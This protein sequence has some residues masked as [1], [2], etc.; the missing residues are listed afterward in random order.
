MKN[1]VL[2]K[3]LLLIPIVFFIGC[4]GFLDVN[5]NPNS[6]E[7]VPPKLLLPSV[8]TG[9]AF[10]NGNELNRFAS[11]LM[12][13]NYGAGGSP[14]AWDVYTLDGGSFGNQ[15]RFEIYGGSLVACSKLITAADAIGAKSYT[16]I[17]KIMKAYSFCLATDVWGDVPYSQAL[18]G[19]AGT[20]QPRIDKQ[21]DIYKGNSSLGI[22]SIFDLVREGLTDLSA[23]SKV[24]PAIDDIVYGGTMA[25]WSKAGYTLM[26]KM[27]LQISDAEP[28]LAA[29]IVNEVLTAN[30]Y[31]K[32]N[33]QNLSVNFGTQTGSQSPVYTWSNI[34]TS[35]FAPDMNVSSGYLDLMSGTSVTADVAS[36]LSPTS[37]FVGVVDPRRDLFIK[38]TGSGFTTYQN[39][40]IGTLAASASR[41]R[42][43]DAVTGV[44]G[45]GPVR[46]VTNAMRA[47][48][49][50][51]AGLRIPG[52]ILPAGQTPQTLYQ[53]GIIASMTEAGV[54]AASIT[55][56][57][58][59]PA[60]TLS[61]TVAQKLEQII[62]QKYIAL[63]GN[64]L[65]AWNDRRRTD[66]P[67]FPEHLNAVGID[68]KR[69]RRA[70]YINEEVQRNPNFK[71]VVLPNVRVWWDVQ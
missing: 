29:S 71:N 18:Q 59:T 6:P 50:A 39:G 28:A 36:P 25:N 4:N 46:L 13:Y 68:G 62:I 33:A 32:T 51:E 19:D 66:Y 60:G 26:L 69:P 12:D 40:F 37:P 47:F 22:Q 56:Y 31:I 42:W 21:E 64:G 49:L 52:V 53:E 35:L 45:A 2:Y 9:A 65:E 58:S 14:A 48:I 70:Q 20:I 34:S 61:G 15:W 16:G 57:L 24:N 23:T 5:Q 30:N 8:L 43:G 38:K 63:T 67:A 7:S 11:T 41:S 44:N 10:A 3:T 55:T 1:R 27:A 17:A 54:P